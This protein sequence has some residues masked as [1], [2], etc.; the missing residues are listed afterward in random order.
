MPTGVAIR[1]PRQQLFDAAERILLRAGPNALTSR[2]VTAEAGC[3]KGVLHR[4]FAD[5]DAFL[6]ELV[7]DRIR[8]LAGLGAA[9]GEAAGTGTVAG[10]LTRA[11]TDLF[12]A[13][14]IAV[15]GLVITRDELRARLRAAGSIGIPLMTEASAML[16]GY[17]AAERDLGRVAADADVA[18][19]AATLLGAAHLLFADREAGPPDAAAV[20]RTVATVLAGAVR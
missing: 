20:C 2:A 15:V 1:D 17:L 4:H 19:L 8:R 7:L 12:D 6:A 10:N 13:V 3:A 11:L 14:A 5:F 9:L 16:T 18:L